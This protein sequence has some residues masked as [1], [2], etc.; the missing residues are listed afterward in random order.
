MAVSEIEVPDYLKDPEPRP[1][2]YTIISVDDH[3]VEPPEMFK[4]REPSR[5]RGRFPRV[6]D[7]EKGKSYSRE[8]LKLN[9]VVVDREG[10]QAW[11]YEGRLYLQVGLNAVAGYTNLSGLAEE[12]AS[13]DQMRPGCFDIR[14]RV[15][16]MDLGGIW[17]SMNFPSQIAGFGGL[18]FSRSSDVELGKAVTRA[19]NDWLYE[20]WYSPF[21]DR[22]IPLGITFLSDPVE[23]AE[24]I[25][26][27]AERGFPAVTFP[28]MPHKVGYPPVHSDYWDPLFRACEETGT[29]V[30]LH[31]G[32]SG[33]LER[34][35]G[36]GFAEKGLALLQAASLLT[37]V[38]WLWS[39]V[40][41]KYP[42]LNIVLSEGGIGW[43]AML[44]DRLDYVVDHSGT[45]RDY[46]AWTGGRHPSELLLDR[47]WFCTIDD[48]ST[49]CTLDRIGEDHVM[50]EVDYPHADSTWPDTQYLLQRRFESSQLSEEQIR[51]VT[52][53]NAAKLFRHP[54]PETR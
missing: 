20:G 52:H 27:N 53:L 28:E 35:E 30:C 45:A 40:P 14:A 10:R 49:L 23:G 24:E 51:K 46:R 39:G 4:D 34:P 17:A 48:P 37:C 21:P 3:L 19:W 2:T 7:L 11:E 44:L 5:F 18:I 36:A 38:E 6:V 41:A 22:I 13:F 26:R 29:A 43:V 12:P 1:T 54:L 31:S 42:N 8:H 25:R 33:L 9:P 15:H 47:F 32:S 16:D 50:V